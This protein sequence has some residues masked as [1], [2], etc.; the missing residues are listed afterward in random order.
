MTR[1]KRFADGAG[2]TRHCWEC[3]HSHEWKRTAVV[4]GD[5]RGSCAVTGEPVS[6]FDSPHN[7]LSRLP[8][9]CDYWMEGA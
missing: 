4:G 7:L 5:W 3:A 2:F 1:R 8:A 6:R 9:S